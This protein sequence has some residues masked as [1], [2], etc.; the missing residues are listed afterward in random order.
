MKKRKMTA[1]ESMIAGAKSALAFA[2][3]E[4]DHGC[5]V[6][7]PTE[8]DVKTIREKVDMSQEE[9]ARQFGFSKRTLQHWEQG[10]RV[11]TGPARAFLTVMIY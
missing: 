8:I 3:G 9:F 2:R 1:G 5:I 7:I 4:P 6:H 10:V 11:P